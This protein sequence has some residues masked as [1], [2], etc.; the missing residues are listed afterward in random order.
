METINSSFTAELLYTFSCLQG[1]EVLMQVLLSGA[2]PLQK[3]VAAYLVLMKDPQPAELAQLAAAL[4]IEE[5]QQ[6]K[7][8]VISHLTNILASTA[9]ETQEYVR[10]IIC[11]IYCLS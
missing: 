6:A 10:D 11:S 3:R 2:S 9:A 5:D 7:S 8:F 1:R 4:P